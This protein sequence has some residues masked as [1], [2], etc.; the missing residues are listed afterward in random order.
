MKARKKKQ[1]L[2]G[3]VL[4]KLGRLRRARKKQQ[5]SKLALKRKELMQQRVA[6]LFQNER[7]SS[8]SVQLASQV[9][10]KIVRE[11]VEVVGAG[12]EF[13]DVELSWDIMDPFPED[14]TPVPVHVK[15]EELDL[16][17]PLLLQTCQDIKV[18]VEED[19]E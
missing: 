13:D 16:E 10:K 3:Q 1:D 8:E 15:I 6:K 4:R 14:E 11:H 7:E 12:D 2:A 5:P 17:D 18:E 19:F 9:P